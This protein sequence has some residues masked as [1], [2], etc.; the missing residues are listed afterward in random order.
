MMVW[1]CEVGNERFQGLLGNVSGSLS[2]PSL[3]N[4]PRLLNKPPAQTHPLSRLVEL[5]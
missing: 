2:A 1:S 3:C 4:P 5:D